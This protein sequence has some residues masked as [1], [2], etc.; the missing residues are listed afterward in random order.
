MKKLFIPLSILTFFIVSCGS[1][2]VETLP[3]LG[4]VYLPLS[5]GKTTIFDVDSVIYRQEIKQGF[6]KIDTNSW[7]IQEV[8]QDTFRDSEG[9]LSYRIDRFERKKGTSKWNV[10]KVFSTALTQRYALRN[11][12]NLRY[13]KFPNYFKEKTVW[14]GNVFNDTV[15]IVANDDI[16]ELFS[17]QWTFTVL[18]FGKSEKI[19]NK[20]YDDVLTVQ[21]Q[22]DP[23]I[24]TEKR[25]VLEKYA[26]GIGL[27]SKVEKILDT[28]K[29][30]G[31]IEW[32]KRAEKGFIVKQTI[33]N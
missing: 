11:E 6:V 24:L 32:E 2:E 1:N 9:N 19:G 27:V 10:T 23:K 28:Q 16:L 7:Q 31:N 22:I 29:L 30:D 12:N 3:E 13:I 4:S 25:F 18:S 14:N 20:L 26:K 21:S 15:K 5:I 33:S 8:L 17:K